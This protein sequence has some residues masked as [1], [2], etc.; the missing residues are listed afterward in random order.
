L[1]QKCNHF[2]IV[3]GAN[4]NVWVCPSLK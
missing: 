4:S 3:T 2:Y 1:S